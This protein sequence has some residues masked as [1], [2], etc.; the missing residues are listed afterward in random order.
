[1]SYSNQEQEL[2]N[3]DYG[4]GAI[5]SWKWLARSSWCSHH[6]QFDLQSTAMCSL[7][8]EIL[9]GDCWSG[10][11]H[12]N[13]IQSLYPGAKHTDQ[14]I[15]KFVTHFWQKRMSFTCFPPSIGSPS[16]AL[17]F[18]SYQ[19]CWAACFSLHVN[20][21]TI[22][23]PAHNGRSFN[24][25]CILLFG[26]YSLT[27]RKMDLSPKQSKQ[28][29]NCGVYVCITMR[30]LIIRRL[31]QANSQ[32]VGRLVYRS[33]GSCYREQMNQCFITGLLVIRYYGIAVCERLYLIASIIRRMR[34]NTLGKISVITSITN[35]TR[36]AEARR[37]TIL[38]PLKSLGITVPFWDELNIC[39]R[40]Y[41]I[42][43]Y[44]RKLKPTRLSFFIYSQTPPN[45]YWIR[46]ILDITAPNIFHL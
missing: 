9:L 41:L 37:S 45:S 16:Y 29:R 1:M 11:T 12:L 39:H 13:W 22:Q 34:Q 14:L 38:F 20:A 40:I 17:V 26:W 19:H 30:Y 5:I 35:I 15:R 42:W 7:V 27:L 36:N 6:L 25:N 21:C 32:Q 28:D 43:R 3:C 18:A 2:T 44:M 10:K 24:K 31:L 33:W 23:E 4:L 46:S 8:R